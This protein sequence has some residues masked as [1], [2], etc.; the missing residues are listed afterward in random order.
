M[1]THTTRKALA[2]M[3]GILLLASAFYLYDLNTVSF[4]EDESWMA[5]AIGDG[6]SDVWDFATHRGVHPPLYFYLAY[7]MKPFISDT[8]Y[9]LRW[10]G[11][12]VTL[13][14]VAL[15]FCLGRDI[16]QDN[17]VGILA[18]L[19]VTGSIYL[20]YLTR[21]ARHYT[22][23]YSLS[24]L[25]Y[26]LYWRWQ[27]RPNTRLILAIMIVQA[28]LLYTHYFGAFTAM[29]IA[30]HAL[31]TR[32]PIR[33][34]S[35]QIVLA[36]IGSGILYMPWLPSIWAQL[37]GD[38]GT[39]VYYAANKLSD[40]PINYIGRITNANALFGIGFLVAGLWALWQQKRGSFTLLA[41][42]A[43]VGTFIPIIIINQ[44]LFQ[45]YIGRNMLY[46]LP[47]VAVF[48]SIGLIH[49]WRN[50]ISKVVISAF[51]IAFIGWGLLAYEDF[52]PGTAD[53]RGIM[54]V[55]ADSARPSDTFVIRGEPY[56]TDYY[57]RRFLDTRVTLL[58]M[59]DWVAEP[60][61]SDRI[62][63]IDSGQAVRFEAIAQ[64]PDN[65]MMTRRLVRLPVVAEF[66]QRVPDAP[67]ATFD[68]QIAVGYTNDTLTAQAGNPLTIDLWWQ[69]VRTPDFNY[70]ASVQLWGD[71]RLI[72]Q[73][74]GNFDNGRMDAQVLPVGIWTPDTR[75]LMIPSD[76]PAGIYDVRI[77]VYDWRDNTRL[78]VLPDDSDQLATITQVI[79]GNGE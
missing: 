61:Y 57:L 18:A 20:L 59:D 55:L 16:S 40:I 10:M 13:I 49:L 48:Y 35:W 36:F 52:Y 17:R 5:I 33:G 39:G 11:G 26:W 79:V 9:A 68:E 22:L 45:W 72:A 65:M 15:T 21:L 58:P 4:W 24:A 30:L 1:M 27:A 8:E 19:I 67:T 71:A 6:V 7:V 47:L 75:Q 51:M 54:D 53:W 37:N 41:L 73:A 38:L 66:Y 69:A 63:L 31:L 2:A 43:I 77:T 32:Q 46:T 62:W 60:V 12:L 76:T 3:V 50:S 28:A 56:S 42:L 74:D 78:A 14:G 29:T 44:T 34:K 64:I 25:I 23:F 70:S